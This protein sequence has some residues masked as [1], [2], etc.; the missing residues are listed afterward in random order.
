MLN[1]RYM[2]SLIW[3][4][5]LTFVSEKKVLPMIPTK[6]HDSHQIKLFLYFI[7]GEKLHGGWAKYLQNSFFAKICHESPRKISFGSNIA[8]LFSFPL[9]LLAE[10]QKLKFESNFPT[11]SDP[12]FCQGYKN[13]FSLGEKLNILFITGST[14]LLSEL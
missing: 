3:T 10:M 12:R 4:L 9:W 8:E 14:F 5:T 7:H 6:V 13:T 2:L 1:L 11:L